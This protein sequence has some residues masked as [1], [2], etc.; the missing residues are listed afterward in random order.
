MVIDNVVNFL[1]FKQNCLYTTG[2]VSQVYTEPGTNK[3]ILFPSVPANLFFAF[4]STYK[5]ASE[6]LLSVLQK[7]SPCCG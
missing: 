2:T 1:L 7:D 5:G 4:I 6:M 3:Y